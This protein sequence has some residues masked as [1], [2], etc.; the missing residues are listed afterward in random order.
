VNMEKAKREITPANIA[1]VAI[2]IFSFILFNYTNIATSNWV[3]HPDD[4]EAFLI[5]KNLSESGHLTIEEPLN[6]LFN[7]PVFTPSG[8]KWDGRKVVPVRAYGLYFLNALGFLV[9]DWLP[10]FMIPIMGLLGMVFFYKLMSMIFDEKKALL[11]LFLLAFSVPIIYWNNMLYSNIP[12]LTFLIMGLYFLVKI[13]YGRSN[14]LIYYILSVTCFALAIWMRYEQALFLLLLLPLL[15]RYRRSFRPKFLIISLLVF[16][17]LLSPILALNQAVYGNP[18]DVGYTISAQASQKDA[19]QNT[20]EPKPISNL[21][22]IFRRFFAQDINPDFSRIYKNVNAYV[23]K[24]FPILIIIGVLGLFLTL[25]F[26]NKNRVLALCLFLIITLWT[27]DTCGGFH[28]GEDRFLVGSTYIRYFLVVYTVI[29]IFAP[30]FIER[31]GDILG[32][33]VFRAL[34]ALFLIAFLV[35]Q[36]SILLSST[37]DLVDTTKQKEQFKG[38]EELSQQLPEDA[39]IVGTIYTK[40]IMSRYVLNYDLIMDKGKAAATVRYIRVL[41]SI[42]YSV[43]LMESSWHSSSYQNVAVYILK[44]EPDIGLEETGKIPAANDKIYRVYFHDPLRSSLDMIDR[45][46]I[47]GGL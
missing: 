24:L 35:M 37:F 31:M 18:F 25:L 41:L 5:G 38:I 16:L 20:V 44:N 19:T 2:L 28:W 33:K 36:F 1:L 9:S 34:L 26:P 29:I 17:I 12:G 27:F 3:V 40:A 32:G 7:D 45:G 6:Y 8:A 39:I 30:V 46:P 10:F 47:E 15:I 22:K 21:E 42:G 11:A 4:H 23:F 43:Y 14:R 13:S